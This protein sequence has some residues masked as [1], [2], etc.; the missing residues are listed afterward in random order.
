MLLGAAHA[1]LL[2]CLPF[3]EQRRPCL[4][5]SLC[6]ASPALPVQG[7]AA[8]PTGPM[9]HNSTSSHPPHSTTHL[10]TRHQA[11]QV[12]PWL[13]SSGLPPVQAM[14]AQSSN[15]AS[16]GQ[17][18]RAGPRYRKL[19]KWQ[20]F[21]AGLQELSWVLHDL[22]LGSFWRM[23]GRGGMQAGPGGVLQYPLKAASYASAS[24][25]LARPDWITKLKG[26]GYE[27]GASTLWI[28]EG[29]IM[30]ITEQDTHALF[31]ACLHSSGPASRLLVVSASQQ[32]IESAKSSTSELTRTWKFGLD[33]PQVAPFFLR[34]GWRV[35]LMQQRGDFTPDYEVDGVRIYRRIR[36]GK[37]EQGR[38]APETFKK[39][40]EFDNPSSVGGRGSWFI[41][42]AKSR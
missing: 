18:F 6:H 13:P 25:D 19:T 27:A 14:Q 33:A 36:K 42:A 39:D 24:C 35:L 26:L 12:T 20:G 40:P 9:R 1:T 32:A 11:A 29:L 34:S 15:A 10:S 7:C 28:A 17:A 4:W 41:V 31:Q 5:L 37:L 16:S 30:Y 2:Y 21:L 23:L 38:Q 3:T 22:L 8:F